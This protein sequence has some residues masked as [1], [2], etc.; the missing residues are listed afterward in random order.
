MIR[1]GLT[2]W[3]GMMLLAA[4][5]VAVSPVA[6]DPLALML[7]ATAL[8]SAE[9]TRLDA[10]DAVI[11]VLPASDPELAVFGITR[12]DI[13]GDRLIAWMRQV[14]DLYASSYMPAIGRL[15]TPPVDHDVAN[16]PISARDLEDLR[17]CRPGSC[18]V[19]LS[20]GEIQR[21][22]QA[23]VSAGDNWKLAVRQAMQAAMLD[24]ARHY[25]RNGFCGSQPYDDHTDSVSAETE[26]AALMSPSGAAWFALPHLM[27]L[28]CLAPVRDPSIQSLLYWSSDRIGRKDTISL[29]HLSLVRPNDD[30]LPEVVAVSRQVF[31]SHY[32]TG[33]LAITALTRGTA[34]TPRYLLYLNRS[35]I[36]VLKGPFAGLAR[37]MI[38]RRL[39]AEAP[40]SL[41]NLRRRL[42]SGVPPAYPR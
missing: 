25:L 3:V 9:R 33:S 2:F 4:A 34:S 39:K 5:P 32:V 1:F 22:Q 23:L 28:T 17:R 40:S 42:E 20:A 27:R 10:G 24:R 14:E 18:S 16:L 21:V 12:I 19:K 29:T 36:D 30:R 7:P 41:Q 11:K 37:H 13:D 26:F 35:R 15:S 8:G 38:E 31:A 6:T